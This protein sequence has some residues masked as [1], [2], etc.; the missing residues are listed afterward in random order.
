VEGPSFWA[1]TEIELAP[2]LISA[3]VEAL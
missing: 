3:T 1:T 2:A